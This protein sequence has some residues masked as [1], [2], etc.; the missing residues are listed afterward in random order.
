MSKIYLDF[1]R[2]LYDTDNFVDEMLDE[3]AS[4]VCKKY[5]EVHPNEV[6]KFVKEKISAKQIF[7]IFSICEAVGEK[8]SIDVDRFKECVEKALK[9]GEKRIY[10]DAITLL[11]ALS[12]K[13]YQINIL[14]YTTKPDYDYQLKKLE[15]SRITSL[16][17]NII[18]TSKEK[19]SLGLD[20]ENSIFV[21]DNPKDLRSLHLSGVKK[22]NLYRIKRKN[23]KY[24]DLPITDFEIKEIGSF[25]EINI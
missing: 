13:G 12:Q 24:S 8:Y 4:I 3:M 10:T 11:K 21:D 18:I 6:I 1:D 20:Y 2:T 23:T 14:T 5:Q 25:D 15:G 9:N 16:I 22:E 17:D 19:G 7:G